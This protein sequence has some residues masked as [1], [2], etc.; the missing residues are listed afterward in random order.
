MY[1]RR[2]TSMF[3]LNACFVCVSIHL[4]NGW[5]TPEETEECEVSTRDTTGHTLY[6]LDTGHRSVLS[7]LQTEK[8]IAEIT[9]IDYVECRHHRYQDEALQAQVEVAG[10]HIIGAASLRLLDP[11]H[12]T[13]GLLVPETQEC[14]NLRFVTTVWS[15]LNKIAH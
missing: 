5:E 11:V 12:H 13:R 9:H 6:I 4:L 14:V 7:R 10:H 2:S 3:L 15:S 1:Q 8:H